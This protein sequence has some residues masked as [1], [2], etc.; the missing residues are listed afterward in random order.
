MILH[1]VILSLASNY[2]Q[3]D[4]LAEAHRR[5][6]LML[7]CRRYTEAIWTEPINARRP[8]LYLNQLLYAET[9]LRVE[10]L[11]QALKDIELDMG[12]TADDRREGL[13]RIDLDLLQYD[14]ERFHLRDWERPYVKKLL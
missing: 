11:Q 14:D 9:T 13:V 6:D 2:Q 7:R 10:E 5:L 4:N 3:Q 12:R 1:K 8:N